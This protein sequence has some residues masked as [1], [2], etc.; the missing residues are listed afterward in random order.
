VKSVFSKAFHSSPV[1]L[2]ISRINDGTFIDVNQSFL[3][4]FGY[5]KEEI[6]GQK[7]TKIVMYD[8]PVDRNRIIQLLDGQ[9][10]VFNHEVTART[11]AGGR[12]TTL[13]SAEKIELNGRTCVIW[14]TIDI[15]ERKE[16]EEK[17]IE[18]EERYRALIDLAPDAILVH[19][20]GNIYYANTSALK[21]FGASTHEELATHNILDLIH[22]DD[23]ESASASIQTVEQGKT[24]MMT[25]RRAIRL[26]GQPWV[27]EAAGTPIRWKN[28][29]CVQVMIRDITARKKNTRRSSSTES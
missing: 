3:E 16:A 19:H 10:K 12:I 5:K 26:D 23:R 25:E 27:L 17:L 20:D 14:T 18:S 15:T 4:L 21:L 11:K 13:V 2:S 9:G 22:P 1:G 6:I 29:L 8:N 28:E 7:A 24:T